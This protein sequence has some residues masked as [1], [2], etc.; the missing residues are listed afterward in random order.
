MLSSDSGA[1][2]TTH[3]WYLVAPA[4]AGLLHRLRPAVRAG[5][6]G[7]LVHLQQDPPVPGAQLGVARDGELSWFGGLSAVEVQRAV[8]LV[9]AGDP[10]GLVRALAHRRTG[11][12]PAPAPP[13]AAR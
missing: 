7:V 13:G 5:A 8:G 1:V 10:A 9:R 3:T 6:D 11:A 12:Q 4:E 2:D